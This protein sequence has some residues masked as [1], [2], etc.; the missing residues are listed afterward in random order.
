MAFSAKNENRTLAHNNTIT[1]DKREHAD[2]E[3][4]K[5]EEGAKKR[6]EGKKSREEGKGEKEREEERKTIKRLKEEG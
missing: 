3:E 6:E 5:E 4:G 2:R 1:K